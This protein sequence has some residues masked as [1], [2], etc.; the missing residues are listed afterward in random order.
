[1]LNKQ[2]PFIEGFLI[3]PFDTI[4]PENEQD[5]ELSKKIITNE[6]SGVFNWILEGLNRLLSQK[7]FT[8]SEVVNKQLEE[9]KKQSDSVL[10]FLDEECYEKSNDKHIL[11][12]ELYKI[13]LAYCS[14]SNYRACS[15]GTF[16]KRLQNAGFETERKNFGIIVF[17]NKS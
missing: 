14:E 13:Y 6:L 3:V 2:M 16:S 1:M 7:N 15:K 9:Y 17:V 11:F 5:K 4:I 12:Q 8:Q 10:M